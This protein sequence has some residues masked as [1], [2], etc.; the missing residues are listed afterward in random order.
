[1]PDHA[2]DD[3]SF[4]DQFPK[5]ASV[6]KYPEPRLQ[7]YWTTA[8]CYIPVSDYGALTGACRQLALD[9]LAAHL[10]TLADQVNAGSTPGMVSAATIDKVSVSLTTAPAADQWSWWLGLTGFGQQLLA[11]LS[12]VS[13]GGF[14][15][16]GLPET[17]AFRKVHGVF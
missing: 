14:Y 9:L 13:I 7:M 1:M 2:Y 12:T 5:F 4:R 11:L 6:I 16:G 15:V 8:S 3:A 10:A 17:S